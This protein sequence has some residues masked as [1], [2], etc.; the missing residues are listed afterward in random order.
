ME[1]IF[2]LSPEERIDNEKL[3]EI[4]LGM[5]QELY[6]MAAR[7][8]EATRETCIRVLDR[9]LVVLGWILAAFA[10]LAAALVVQ[11]TGEVK[12]AI[13]IIMTCY[14]IVCAAVLAV[15]L[16]K[17]ALFNVYTYSSGESP[18]LP[19]R[20]EALDVV[21]GYGYE[22]KQ[23]H[24]LGFQLNQMQYY[25]MYNQKVNERL[26]KTYRTTVWLLMAMIAGASALLAVLLIV[27]A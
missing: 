26:L 12:N 23:K 5:V 15:R 13:M 11:L 6:A 3:K 10:S 9:C 16:I 7:K 25:Q 18:Y 2:D 24:L 8:L 22:D 20:K 21:K 27:L 4:N 14:A 1:D 17:G 19:I